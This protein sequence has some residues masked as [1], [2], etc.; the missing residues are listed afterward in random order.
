MPV[1]AQSKR[2]QYCLHIE[3]HGLARTAVILCSMQDRWQEKDTQ[4]CP[5][6]E[7]QARQMLSYLH[8]MNTQRYE[9]F[10]SLM[11]EHPDARNEGKTL[12]THTRRRRMWREWN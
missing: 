1:I 6:S 4:S 10:L 11:T 7:R 5:L 3:Q 8:P 9:H 12:V 2:K